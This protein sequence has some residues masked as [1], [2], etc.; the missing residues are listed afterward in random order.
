MARVGRISKQTFTSTDLK[1]LAEDP[2]KPVVWEQWCGLV[3]RGRPDTLLLKRLLPMMSA[4][5]AP[6]PG[7][8]RK[9][10]WKLLA[11]KHLQ[12]RR[13][14]LHSDAAKSYR[15]R[16]P[17]VLHDHVRHCKKRVKVK[18]KWVWKQPTY[19]KVAVHTDPATGK[20]MKTKGGTQIS[21]R[22]WRY[23]KDRIKLNQ[24][25]TVGSSLLR[26]KI[27]SAQYEYWHRNADMWLAS[28]VI[29]GWRNAK[30]TE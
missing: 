1:D 5:R 14:I 26:A 8:I 12:D 15:L 7:A 22:A 9:V 16:L 19:V 17:G 4:K 10:E 20:K 6:G 13:V 28:G 23:L 27:R 24:K 21:D 2:K 25:C 11:H 18:S 29:C 3:Q 30:N